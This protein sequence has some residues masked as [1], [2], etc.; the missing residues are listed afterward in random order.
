MRI[1]SI[2]AIVSG[3]L[4]VATPAYADAGDILIKARGT[5]SVRSGSFNVAIGADDATRRAKFADAPGLEGSITMF[6][7]DRIAAEVSIGGAK[8]DVEDGA[9]GTL[10]E[11]SALTTAASIQYHFAGNEA[12][13][14]P[15][16]G[17][18]GAYLNFYAEDA[19]RVFLD[20]AESEFTSYSA[21]MD[22]KF[23]PFAQIGADVPI[24]EQIY[25]NFDVKYV[26]Y[27]SEQLIE[28][29]ARQSISRRIDSMVAAV[30]IGF[31]F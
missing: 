28:T 2:L 1:L 4:S 30:G 31:R 13:F 21:S 29:Q 19:G 23:A 6:L 22:G 18:G 11:G 20:Q 3:G 24:N 14:R 8:H 9:G 16:I 25:V 7:S 10:V 5:Y 17:A 27:K 15:Y 26:S 12:S